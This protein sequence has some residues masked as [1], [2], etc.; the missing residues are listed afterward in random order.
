VESAFSSTALLVAIAAVL[1][2]V[3]LVPVWV[4]R[5]EYLATER[6]ATR[7]GQTLRVLAETAETSQE[8]RAELTAREVW[9]RSR[10]AERAVSEF[11]LT[12]KQKKAKRRRQARIVITIFTGISFAALVGAW[13][14][15]SAGWVIGATAG[16]VATGLLALVVIAQRAKGHDAHANMAQTTTQRPKQN[17]AS[18]RAWTPPQIPEPLSPRQTIPNASESLPSREE[19]LR[20]ARQAAAQV[21]PEEV[22]AEQEKLAPV[23]RFDQMGVISDTPPSTR[24]NLD[25]VLQRRRAV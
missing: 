8:L 22:A 5:S 19:L 18:P 2:I 20:Q 15:G 25:E 12:D 24:P 16:K 10:Q 17:Q 9:Q 23:S 14:A 11:G 1:W 13:A 6:N 3:Y 7:L 4:K 21:R